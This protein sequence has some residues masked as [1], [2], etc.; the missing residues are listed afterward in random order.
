MVVDLE[1]ILRIVLHAL[2]YLLPASGSTIPHLIKLTVVTLGTRMPFEV[3]NVF[4]TMAGFF[5]NL[6]GCLSS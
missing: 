1:W 3:S 2:L 6:L 4:S 5:S